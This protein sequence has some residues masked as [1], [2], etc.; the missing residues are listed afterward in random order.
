MALTLSS[1]ARL[2][3]PS[4]GNIEQ[5]GQDIGSLSARRRQRG[6]LTDLLGP[7]TD[8]M[9]T[10]AD[11][12]A[13]SRGLLQVDPAIAMQAAG[14]ARQAA[15]REQEEERRPKTRA[16]YFRANPE[17]LAGLYEKFSSDSIEAFVGNTGPL[18]PLAKNA[19]DP[20]SSYG[21]QLADAGI[22]PGSDAFITAMKDFNEAVITGRTKGISY[23]GPLEQ[24]EFLNEA[25]SK[26]P[27]T[28]TKNSIVQKVNQVESIK[29]QLE[30]GNQ[31]PEAIA[32]LQRVTS[33][34][35]NTDTRAA[36]EIDRL[37]QNK[38]FARTFADAVEGF[39]GEGVTDVSRKNLLDIVQAM[40]NV[41]TFY[42]EQ[43]VKSVLSSYG[44]NVDEKVKNAFE[45]NNASPMFYY[46]P[47]KDD[48]SETP[49]LP[50]GA[51]LDPSNPFNS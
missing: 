6:M 44:A 5:L 23:K 45:E 1:A 28:L 36:S 51:T 10:S 9:A 50:P 14:A 22:K 13:A 12:A 47:E 30:D 20:L 2:A 37:T 29:R 18:Q 16:D 25:L 24:T 32:L 35:F 11:L 21:K 17:E 38:G 8:P 46:A 42:H 31:T 43:S 4:F 34:L 39:T 15:V 19:K 40:K 48:K 33:E 41:A 26:N 27:F 7:L 49:P 3:N